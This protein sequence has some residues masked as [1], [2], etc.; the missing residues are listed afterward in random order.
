LLDPLSTSTHLSH[1][2][3]IFWG[4]DRALQGVNFS[5]LLIF[6]HNNHNFQDGNGC[7]LERLITA[8][9]WL[10]GELGTCTA[11]LGGR[12]FW[13]K[14]KWRSSRVVHE[15]PVGLEMVPCPSPTSVFSVS[16]ETTC[17]M[18]ELF[19]SILVFLDC[20]TV[21]WILT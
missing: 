2:L 5:Y 15:V 9:R 11:S 12:G 7:R 18:F 17:V 20:V 14:R 1:I 21:F 8:S 6:S 13:W 3:P 4:L 19:G 10:I 16:T